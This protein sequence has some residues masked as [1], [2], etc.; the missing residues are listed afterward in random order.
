MTATTLPSS[1][2]GAYLI[3]L[4][5]AAFIRPAKVTTFMGGFAGTL[6]AHFI[7]L[8]LRIL[9]GTSLI[10]SAPTMRMPEV[11]RAFGWVLVGT[12]LVLLMLPWRWHRRFAQWSVPQATANLPLLGIASIVGGTFLLWALWGSG[13]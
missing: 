5:V 4:G 1:V 9:V 13:V 2:A 8:A 7:E 10:A 6:R 12:S 3:A 11:F